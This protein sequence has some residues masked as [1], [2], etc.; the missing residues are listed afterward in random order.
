MSEYNSDESSNVLKIAFNNQTSEEKIKEP[1]KRR[2]STRLS[3]KAA[4]AE[5]ASKLASKNINKSSK[6][7]K[8]LILKQKK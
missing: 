8:D 5:A 3:K 4:A 2:N 7:K 1:L 6:V